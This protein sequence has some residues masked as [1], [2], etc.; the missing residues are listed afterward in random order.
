MASCGTGV[1]ACILA[2]VINYLH[3]SL[4]F[5]IILYIYI[6]IYING[7]GES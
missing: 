6:Y 2:M 4:L 3:P 7:A 5:E 1:T